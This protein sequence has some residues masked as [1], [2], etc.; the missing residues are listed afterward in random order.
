MAEETMAGPAKA[1]PEM[2]KL[3]NTGRGDMQILSGPNGTLFAGSKNSIEVP[4]ELA[5]KLR[6][7]YPHV[8]NIL[9]I[10][11]DSPNVDAMKAE[12]AALKAKAAALEK[13]LDASDKAKGEAAAAFA[14][15][16]AEAVAS[17]T[18]EHT[19][20]TAKIAEQG[21]AIADLSA[22]LEDFRAAK[23][24]ADIEAIKA[25]HEEAEKAPAAA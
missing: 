8:K 4:K 5:D 22:K 6:R 10:F 3:V 2:I 12:N 1:E 21:A 14:G 11:P 7:A 19:D 23:N 9:D 20:L 24:K 17:W 15:E 18:K 25:K 16:K 13:L